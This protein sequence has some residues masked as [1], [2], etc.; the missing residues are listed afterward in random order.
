MD[1]LVLLDR[2]VRDRKQSSSRLIRPIHKHSPTRWC[3][4][5][6]SDNM[7]QNDIM[8]IYPVA[9]DFSQAMVIEINI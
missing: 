6:D 4:E 2:I 5:S 1:T 9:D 3:S 7:T 8:T